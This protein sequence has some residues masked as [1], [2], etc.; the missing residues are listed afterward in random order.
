MSKIDDMGLLGRQKPIVNSLS[1]AKML[2]TLNNSMFTSDKEF[3]TEKEKSRTK[4]S[5]LKKHLM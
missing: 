1:Y 3:S 4:K 5:T 2:V